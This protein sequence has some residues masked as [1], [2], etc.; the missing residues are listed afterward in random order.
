MSKIITCPHCHNEFT[1]EP[2]E[3]LLKPTLTISRRQL[4]RGSWQD[5]ADLVDRGE[6]YR[7]L[8]VGD[9]ISCA[10]KGGSNVTI[11]VLDINPYGNDEVIFGFRDSFIDWQ[12]NQTNTNAGGFPK[13][14]MLADIEK[15]IIPLLPDD[16]LS[17][18]TPRLIQQDIRNSRSEIP[19]KLW[20]PS[21]YEVF[22]DY[23]EYCC[24]VGE[25]QYQF[26]KEPRNRIKLKRDGK[27]SVFWWLR[28]PNVSYSTYFWYV[29]GYGNTGNFYAFNSSG[30][31]P[32]FA[33][34]KK[35]IK[36]LIAQ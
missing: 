5:I 3:E 33:I 34:C 2:L 36:V 17:V 15:S 29:Y 22:G 23:K 7:M 28:S 13:S 32:C 19:A 20:L 21:L 9:S 8:S 30:V 4:E 24:D 25:R 12:M 10:L 26:F 6:A 14:K 35:D 1:D 27:T 16:L 11:D 18:I 31:C